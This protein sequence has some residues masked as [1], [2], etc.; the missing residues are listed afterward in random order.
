MR[1]CIK[2]MIYMGIILFFI[3]AVSG[4]APKQNPA[5]PVESVDGAQETETQY[6]WANSFDY[7]IDS[8]E[9]YYYASNLHDHYLYSAN[10]DGSDARRVAS[11]SAS[12]IC[13]QDGM[14][15]FIHNGGGGYESGIYRIQTNGS[16]MEKLC[17]WGRQLRL[18]EGYVYFCAAYEAEY[19]ASGLVTKT[20][21]EYDDNFL[22]RMKKDG[23]DRK[24]I[25]T[26]V[27]DFALQYVQDEKQMVLYCSQYCH[28]G[29]MAVSRMASDGRDAQALWYTDYEGTM[30]VYKSRIYFL[31]IYFGSQKVEWYDLSDGS[32][33]SFTV[34]LNYSYNCIY[35]DYFYGVCES[36]SDNERKVTVYRVDLNGRNDRI[37]YEDSYD[38]DSGK[39]GAVTYLYATEKGVLFRPYVPEQS[40]VRWF[41]LTDD[42]KVEAWETEDSEDTEN[43]ADLS[44]APDL[45]HNGTAEEV[46]LTELDDGLGQRLEIWE[47]DVL[48]DSE[49]GYFAHTGQTS[50]F[51]CTLD[52]EDYLLRYRPTMYQ[53]VCLYEYELS[54]LKNNKKKTI[55]YN[56]VDFD[57]NFGSPYHTGFDAEAVVAF[58]DEINDLLAHSV[59]L[60]NTDSDLQGTFEKETFEKGGRLYDSLWW[61][62]NQEPVFVRNE[63]KSLLENLQDFQAAMTAVQK[64]TAI[65]EVG[66][67]PITE[68]LEMSF[69]SGAGAWMTELTLNP[70]GSFVGD[71]ADADCDTIYVC[72]FHGQFGG[73]EKITDN[74]WLMTLEELVLDTG[75]S[76]GEEWDVTEDGYTIHYISSD[77]YGFDDADWKTLEPG[78]QFI[79]YSPDATGHEPGTELYGAREFQSWMHDHHGFD[80]E[81]DILGCWGLHNL[82][83][84][85]GFFVDD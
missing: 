75:H 77:P 57:I 72:Q 59:V 84:G 18:S 1:K 17:G 5:V 43:T 46:R 52:G 4:C 62:D 27:R 39:G 26:D 78:A 54:T 6:A 53:G 61:L 45:N 2:R 15:Y 55:Q 36:W 10:E 24:L 9:R 64:P 8:G 22:Y 85:Q 32:T 23:T 49:V 58:M 25:A 33:G 56:Y 3:G 20:P 14:I 65:E 41:R 60:L 37:L 83:S 21:P 69:Y 47:N 11:V 16:G 71:Y 34:P 73:V 48:V 29:T 12:E 67:L 76:V 63:D 68:P 42:G 40:G 35:N 31:D 81:D 30:M 19:D 79:L 38:D 28:D 51:L 50:I 74:S 70:D 44:I 82:A 80:S 7:S 13:V 66:S